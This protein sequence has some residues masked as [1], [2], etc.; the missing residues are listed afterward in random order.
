MSRFSDKEKQIFWNVKVSSLS[1]NEK[2]SN[3]SMPIYQEALKKAGCDY[4]LKYQK[5]TSTTQT[6]NNGKGT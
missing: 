5:N 3:E 6:Q 2:I 4:K 1:S